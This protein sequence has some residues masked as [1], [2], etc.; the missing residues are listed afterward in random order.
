MIDFLARLRDKK[1]P[2]KAEHSSY[3]QIIYLVSFHTKKRNREIIAV[4]RLLRPLSESSDSHRDND[5]QEP[6][7]GI[8]P[9]TY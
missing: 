4:L 5:L 1:K 3:C 9:T 2:P 8:E 6:P 7:V